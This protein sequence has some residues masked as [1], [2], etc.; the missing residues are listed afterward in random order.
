MSLRFS[1]IE[2]AASTQIASLDPSHIAALVAVAMPLR[3]LLMKAAEALAAAGLFKQ[4][5]VDKIRKGY[6]KLDAAQLFGRDEVD[7]KVPPLLSG[8]RGRPK[9]AAPVATTGGG[10][11]TP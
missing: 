11:S 6:G 1:P 10:G 4:A 7:E 9:K 5:D 8:R 2:Q 3:A